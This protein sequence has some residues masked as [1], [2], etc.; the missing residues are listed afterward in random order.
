MEK[1]GLLLNVSHLDFLMAT[2]MDLSAE[3]IN[4][5]PSAL[6]RILVKKLNLKENKSER[7]SQNIVSREYDVQTLQEG[8]MCVIVTWSRVW[9]CPWRTWTQ[10]MQE[11]W[12]IYLHL[13][14]LHPPVAVILF[15]FFLFKPYKF[16]HG[17][18]RFHSSKWPTCI[19]HYSSS[20]FNC[21]RFFS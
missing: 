19:T 15:V 18:G 8:L 7:W 10:K 14:F 3:S 20:F 12:H 13:M 5:G 1:S 2:N 21:H 11:F 16:N 9:S 17:P 6:A 4:T